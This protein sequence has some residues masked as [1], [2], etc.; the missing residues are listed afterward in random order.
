MQECPECG[1]L[2]ADGH[3]VCP[4][5]GFGLMDQTRT[6]EH[7]DET[8]AATAEAC[9]ACGHLA[10]PGACDLHPDREAP[11]QCALCGTTLCDECDAGRRYHLCRDHAKVPIVEGWAQV[12]AVP[13]EVQAQLI[14]EN[15]RAEGIDSRVLSKKDH[16][17]LPVEFGDLANVRVLVPTYAFQEAEHILEAHTDYEGAVSFGC[18]NCGEPYDEGE[19]TCSACGAPLV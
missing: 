11:G 8:I 4:A 18:P 1:T 12:L 17:S 19:T 14:E 3:A 9:P 16:F 7:C 5:C 2:V 10:T 6:C 15:L 13:N